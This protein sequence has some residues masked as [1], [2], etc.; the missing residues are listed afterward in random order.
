MPLV[1]KKPTISDIAIA[2]GVSKTTVSRYLNGKYSLMSKETCNRIK[3]VIEMSN[4]QPSDVARSLKSHRSQLIGVVLADIETPFSS[5]IIYGIC[6]VLDQEGFIPLFVNCNNDPQNEKEYLTSLVAR[7]VEGLVVNTTSYENP[8]LIELACRRLPIV[9]CDRYVKDYNFDIVTTNSS[10]PIDDM[11]T[12]L[13]DQGFTRPILFT[14]DIA[15]SSTRKRR[16]DAFLHGMRKTYGVDDP[17]QYVRHIN[18]S[19]K[20][21]T[22]RM[23][24]ELVSTA[25]VSNMPAAM[26]VNTI[27][28]VH[29]LSTMKDLGLQAPT[30]IGICGPDDWG[31]GQKLDWTSLLD[32]GIT[33]FTIPSTQIG[34]DTAR[35]ILEK[36][37][38][39]NREKEH[40]IYES[41][42]EIRPSTRLKG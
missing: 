29:L 4:Y 14:Q 13:K 42:L 39:P 25:T 11:L 27:T 35:I 15:V 9:L 3:A 31:W 37:K 28:T 7:G 26:G 32:P 18:I 2:A 19:D 34:K 10:Q 36:I 12:H 8:Y 22:A 33:T 30:D 5:A 21:A 40:I 1:Q 6:S 17:E 41:E 24:Q 38:Y 16:H 20:P 23:L